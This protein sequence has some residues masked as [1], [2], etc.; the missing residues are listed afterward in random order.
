VPPKLVEQLSLGG[1]LVIPV[2]R[3]TIQQL[4]S[5]VREREGVTVTRHGQCRFV[6]LIGN[7]AWPE[8]EKP[9]E[10]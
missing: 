6:P 7:E 2:G 4:L 10:Y 9:E 5:V 8:E 3:R 1:R